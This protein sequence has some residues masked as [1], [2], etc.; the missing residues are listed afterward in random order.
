LIDFP[1]RLKFVGGGLSMFGKIFIIAVIVFF[2]VAGLGF[3][4][5]IRKN[6]DEDDF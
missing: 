3:L 6:F 5:G 1:D 2:I 4:N